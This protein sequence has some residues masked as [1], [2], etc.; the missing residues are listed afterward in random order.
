MPRTL[1]RSA[2]LGVGAGQVPFSKKAGDGE[3]NAQ[4]ETWQPEP[5]PVEFNVRCGAWMLLRRPFSHSKRY[6]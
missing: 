1:D 5:N 3:S 6:F 2:T 4:N